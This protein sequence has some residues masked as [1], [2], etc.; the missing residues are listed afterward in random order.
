MKPKVYAYAGEPIPDLN[1]PK[2]TGFLIHLEKS[3]L[4]SLEKR[5]LIS[6]SQRDRCLAG[7]EELHPKDSNK[8]Q[9]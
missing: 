6:P 8:H 4:Y 9:P 7:I 5:A 1:D 2:Y 3:V